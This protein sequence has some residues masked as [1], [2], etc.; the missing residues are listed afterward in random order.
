MKGVILAGGTGSRLAPL[1]RVTNKHL[2]PVFNRPM[3]YYPIATLKK[4]GIE[5]ILVVSGKGHVGHLL[6]LLGSGKRF[7]V[8]FS[9]EV[10]EEPGGIAQALGL[11]KDFIDGGKIIVMLG[12]NILVD[13]IKEAVQ[14]FEKQPSG[15]KIFL[16]ETKYPQ[17]LGIAEIDGD[18]IIN[19]EE[20]PKKPKSNLAV[21]GL[22]MYDSSVFDV[23]NTL[24][25]S[26]RG[27]L[28]ITDVNNY[29]IKESTM[30]YSVL[31]GWW[32]DGGESFESL[33][34]AGQL[35]AKTIKDTGHDPWCTD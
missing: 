8:K 34:E 14:D 16:K 4:A 6:E 18:R 30:T 24:K 20:K 7:G 9:Y 21:I 13:D 33:L 35:V 5:D 2:L 10:Q 3:I 27:E 17:S 22:Y 12:D 28:E 1:T 11:A 15:A 19:I 26:K 29:F 25:P 23:V 31:K 32:G